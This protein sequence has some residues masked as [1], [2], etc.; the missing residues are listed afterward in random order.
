MFFQGLSWIDQKFDEHVDYGARS[1]VG[2]L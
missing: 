2:S 1:I